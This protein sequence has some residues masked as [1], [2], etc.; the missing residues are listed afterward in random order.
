MSIDGSGGKSGTCLLSFG[1]SILASGGAL[2]WG[3][4]LGGDISRSAGIRDELEVLV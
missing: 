2:V 1:F 3:G 4:G